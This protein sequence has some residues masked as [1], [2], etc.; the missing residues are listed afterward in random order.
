MEWTAVAQYVFYALITF[1]AGSAAGTLKELRKS[2]EEL[3]LNM[4]KIIQESQWHERWL[5]RHDEE[6]KTIKEKI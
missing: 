6:L 3:N 4:S 1:I 5:I 2:I